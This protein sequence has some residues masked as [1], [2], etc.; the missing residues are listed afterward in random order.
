MSTIACKNQSDRTNET[1]IDSSFNQASADSITRDSTLLL[2]QKVLDSV[3]TQSPKTMLTSLLEG[4][5]RYGR[6]T[7]FV[8]NFNEPI[9]DSL[10]HPKPYLVVTDIDLPH[11]LEKIFDLKRSMFLQL[12]SPATLTDITEVAAIEYAVKYS[13]SKVIIVL[14]NG[15]SRI[16]GAACDN[17]QTGNFGG[18]AS[19][20]SKAMSSTQ[21][22]AD[23]SSANKAY[24][25]AIAQNQAIL[26]AVK[27]LQQ[28][29]EL[30]TLSDNG[31]III[32][33]AFFNPVKGTVSIIEG[34]D[35]LNSLT[36]K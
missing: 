6:K 14:A 22:F 3:Y 26:S 2:Y 21:E 8:Y 29:P 35:A 13:G 36:K 17:V 34:N 19:Q 28:S 7:A 16:I 25:N 4:S 9:P 18:I 30:K 10:R 27:I 20:L 11:S 32:K 1:D 33:S 31:K 12:A 15:N 5:N 24:V 23:R